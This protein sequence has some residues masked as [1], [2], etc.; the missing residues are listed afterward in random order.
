MTTHTRENL[1]PAERII[2][3]LL[4][5]TDHLY[6][7]RP[8]IV[9]TDARTNVGVRWEPV[10][11]KVEDG[12]KVVYKLSKVGKKTIKARIGVMTEAVNPNGITVHVRT[13]ASPNHPIIGEYREAGLFPEVAAWMYRQVAEV[14]KLDNEF[15]ARWASFAFGQEHR[16]LKVVLAAFMLVQARKGDPV[17]DGGKVAFYDE[18]YRD[19]GEAM[20]LIRRK[21]DKELN[22]KLL[23]RMHDLLT[24]PQIAAINRELGFGTSARK[25]FLGRWSTVV[26]K[27][28]RHREENPRL[29]D[30]LVKAGFKQT[31]IDLAR[32]VG[33][34]PTTSKF[35]EAL[36]WKQAQA[37]DGRRTMAIGLAVTAA[38]T[39]E[40]LS[41]AQVCER[42]VATKPDWKRIVG[43]LPKTVGVTRAVV[44]AAIEAKAL[45][46][47]DLIIATPTLEELGLLD[48]PDI[49]ARWEKATRGAEDSR[50]ANIARNVQSKELKEKLVEAADTAVKKAVEAVTKNMRVYF[51]VDI[52]GSMKNAIEAAK[53][54]IA[55]FLQGFSPERTHVAVFNTTGREVVIKHASAAGVENAFKGISASGGTDYGAGVRVLQHHKPNADE[56]VLFIFVGDEEAVP[57]EGAVTASGLR[58]MAFGFVKTTPDGGAAGWRVQQY[59]VDNN[60]A[61]RDT[62]AR[63]GIPCFMIDEKTFDDAYAIPR[64]V[65]ALVSATPVGPAR[66]AATPRFTLVD[67][68]LKTDLLKKPAWA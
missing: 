26:E 36:R 50:A 66:A 2:N 67:Q 37:D 56:D 51:M 9:I 49:R 12:K 54:Y 34:K 17:V 42:I 61:V 20:M 15:A 22:P 18:D 1:G 63:L 52:S 7:G 46:D 64:T 45:S 29:L 31:V 25:A 13:D 14:W 35:F 19:V 65:R 3:A 16:D 28:L 55:K 62:A 33:Y 38:E 5:Y 27:W 23:L 43:M 53:T 40:D 30:G 48:V 11:H 32:R 47:R 60:V 57:F 44:A 10:T 59:G 8:G 58:P 6:H 39:W 24:L 41:E 68:I 21:D 4:A